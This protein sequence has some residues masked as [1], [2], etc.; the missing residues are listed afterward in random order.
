MPFLG[1]LERNRHSTNDRA[2]NHSRMEVVMV[3]IE[4]SIQLFYTAV[5]VALAGVVLVAYFALFY[6]TMI[7]LDSCEICKSI[8]A[9]NTQK[10]QGHSLSRT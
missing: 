5:L 7:A 9:G 3:M 6:L 4:G 2:I 1:T 8:R 10:A